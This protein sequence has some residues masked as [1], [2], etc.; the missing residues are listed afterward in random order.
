MGED[1]VDRAALV[2]GLPEV[3]SRTA[4]LRLHGAPADGAREGAS[5]DFDAGEPWAV[6][7][8]D[9]AALCQLAAERPELDR[10]LHSRLPYRAVQVVWAARHEMARTVEDVLAR[11]TRALFLDA[12]AAVEAAPMVAELMAAE[13]G[14]DAAWRDRQVAELRE[15]AAGYLPPEP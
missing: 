2:G 3:P 7:G 5:A 8:G 1:A 11:R 13:L 4:G 15:L 12:R 14:R 6:Y 10:P 9:A